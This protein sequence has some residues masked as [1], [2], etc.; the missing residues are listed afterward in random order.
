M[1]TLPYLL[2]V[3]IGCFLV[4]SISVAQDGAEARVK[5]LISE[6][7]KKIAEFG[8]KIQAAAPKDRQKVYRE[9]YP[10][11]KEA[12]AELKKIAKEHP[13]SQAALDAIAFVVQNS[14]GRGVGPEIMDI[15]KKHHLDN[16]GLVDVVV[17]MMRIPT[18][19]AKEFLKLA[20]TESKSKNVRGMAIYGLASGMER[21]KSKADEYKAHLQTLVKDYPDLEY[22]GRNIAKRAEG[23]LFAAEHLAIGKVAPEIVGADVDGKEMKLSDYR[24]KVVVLDFW[25]DW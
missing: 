21:D 4:P 10:N 3:T 1:K 11:P 19:A 23:K 5:E 13:D 2:A 14:R 16:D 22:R 12:V 24:G 6:H 25:G 9:E 8:K 7:Q 15:L 17:S 20:S 18:P